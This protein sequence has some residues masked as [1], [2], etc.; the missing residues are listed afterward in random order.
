MVAYCQ[1]ESGTAA[2]HF[3]HH[4]HRH[5]VSDRDSDETPDGKHLDCGFCHAGSA[6]PLTQRLDSTVS[7]GPAVKAAFPPHL[8]LAGPTSEPERPKWSNPA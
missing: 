7:V 6:L 2:D 3:G 5:Q 8:L 1:H 4:E